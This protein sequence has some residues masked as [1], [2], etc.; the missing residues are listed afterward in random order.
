VHEQ[1]ACSE[2]LDHMGIWQQCGA[3]GLGEG[4]SEQK[5][6]IAMHQMN[7][8]T[9]VRD[10]AQT[11]DHRAMQRL[12][13]IVVADPVIEQVAENVQGAG[14][15]RLIAQKAEKNAIDP[16][17]AWR[18]VKIGDEQDRR[19]EAIRVRGASHPRLRI[20]VM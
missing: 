6:P 18:Q 2:Q 15:G 7:P 4:S 16:I 3:G 12:F 8:A 20:V 13:E 1:R 11:A 9:G 10:L 19:S 14:A 17:A 5:V